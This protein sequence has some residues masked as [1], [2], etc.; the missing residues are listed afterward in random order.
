MRKFFLFVV[1]ALS[2]FITESSATHLRCGLIDIQQ[3]SNGSKTCR[4]TL[5]IYSNTFNTTVLVGGDQDLLD[6]GDGTSI[7]VPETPN[8]IQY[9]MDGRAYVGMVEFTIIHTYADYGSYF[10]SYREPNRNEGILNISNSVNT[11][12]YIESY[13]T[14]SS[15]STYSSPKFLVEPFFKAAVKSSLSLS[16]AAKD[17]NDYSLLYE[18]AIPKMSKDALVSGYKVPNGLVLNDLS[19]VLTWADAGNTIGVGE[20]LFGTKVIQVQNQRVI[21]YSFRD[22]QIVLLDSDEKGRLFIE[23]ELNDDNA[24]I[25]EQGESFSVRLLTESLEAATELEAFSDM[26]NNTSNYSFSVHDS[27][28]GSTFYKVGVLKINTTQEIVRDNPYPIVVRASFKTADEIYFKDLNLLLY[29]KNVVPSPPLILSVERDQ[30]KLNIFPN[31][32]TNKIHIGGLNNKNLC[33]GIY[34]ETGSKVYEGVDSCTDEIDISSLSSGCYILEI[35][36]LR[37]KVIT[38]KKLIK[39]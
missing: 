24:I 23:E 38:R 37:G 35:T 21:G 11:P 30:E 39:E 16:L 13:F 10:V 9:D 34:N 28:S 12:F 19:G 17:E 4:V 5:R 27:I 36:E 7:Y 20:Y 29:T 25:V 8:I 14:L 15:N 31:P 33:L 3:L 32:A 22:I 18:L 6:F 1:I 2:F 26:Q